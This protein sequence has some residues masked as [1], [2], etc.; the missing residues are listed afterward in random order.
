MKNKE[1]KSLWAFLFWK[2]GGNMNKSECKRYLKK[3]Y[4]Q[5]IAHNKSITPKNIEEEMK[6]VI[7][8][9]ADE[10]I[11]YSKIAVDTMQNSANDII[12][13]HDLLEEIDI[14]PKIYTKVT[15]ISMARNL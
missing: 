8:E 12:T 13:L 14:L 11:S 2:N 3:A 9:Q 7:K 10:Y 5:V 6:N 1:S 4:K 15:A